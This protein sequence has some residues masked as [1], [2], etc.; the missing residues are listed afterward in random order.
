MAIGWGI[1]LGLVV[2]GDADDVDRL[3]VCA[4]LA[5]DHGDLILSPAQQVRVEYE[6][7]RGIADVH[8]D[9]DLAIVR[10]GPGVGIGHLC[11][12]SGNRMRI[13]NRRHTTGKRKAEEGC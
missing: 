2:E 12:G 6:A 13:R 10:H 11:A 8:Q 4:R 7:G 3:V 1:T 5:S 9:A